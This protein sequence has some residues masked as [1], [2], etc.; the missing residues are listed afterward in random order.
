MPSY[1]QYNTPKFVMNRN[2][3]LTAPQ[4]RIIG[5]ALSTTGYQYFSIALVG[6]RGG[7]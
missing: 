5:T 3:E 6:H 2:I 1:L 4:F 7:K